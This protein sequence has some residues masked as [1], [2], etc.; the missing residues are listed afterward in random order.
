MF[1][2]FK[3]IRLIGAAWT[4]HD[5]EVTADAYRGGREVDPASIWIRRDLSGQSSHDRAGMLAASRQW[6]RV[7]RVPVQG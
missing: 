3:G 2:A 4:L 7:F 1:L 5:A 6:L